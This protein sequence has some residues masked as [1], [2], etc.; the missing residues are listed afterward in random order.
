MNFTWRVNDDDIKLVNHWV[1][2][3]LNVSF[4]SLTIAV[5]I[6]E[7][8]EDSMQ[9]LPDVLKSIRSYN[10]EKHMKAQTIT[11]SAEFEP[12][13]YMTVMYKGN[14]ANC[15]RLIRVGGQLDITEPELLLLKKVLIAVAKWGKNLLISDTFKIFEANHENLNRFIGLSIDSKQN[16]IFILWNHCA[17]G[18]VKDILHETDIELDFA[19]KSSILRDIIQVSQIPISQAP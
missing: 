1:Q 9:S 8:H 4:K 11:K 18:P 2:G 3:S 16:N 19:F 10:A 12:G 6:L 14:L 17:K 7:L 15:K 5:S 13:H